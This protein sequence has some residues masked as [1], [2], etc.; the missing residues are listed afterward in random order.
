[1][2]ELEKALKAEIARIQKEGVSED[3]LN[4]VKAQVIAAD[5]YQRDSVFYQAMQLGEL[6]VLD[7]PLELMNTRV[8]KLK[9]VTAEQVKEV[10]KML[11]DDRLSVA[12]LD[13][14]PLEN[15]PRKPAISGMRHAN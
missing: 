12:V 13:P 4:R 11:S 7:L 9:S 6:A 14:Q 8:E 3:E 10:A 15:T 2:T 1:V 5:V